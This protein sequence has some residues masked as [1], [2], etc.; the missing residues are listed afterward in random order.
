MVRREIDAV[1][2]K[3]E[4][5]SKEHGIAPDVFNQAEYGKSFAGGFKEEA[6]R[7]SLARVGF[8]G[9]TVHYY[10]FLGQASLINQSPL[11][12]AERFRAVDATH[13][14]LSRTMPLSRHLFKYLG[15]VATK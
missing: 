9:V 5:I 2:H 8:S 3:D 1:L 4:E 7:E 12:Q 13:D 11:G 10:W 15:F 6:L 14:V